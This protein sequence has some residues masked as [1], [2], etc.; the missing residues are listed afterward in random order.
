MVLDPMGQKQLLDAT[1]TK[2]GKN[3]RKRGLVKRRKSSGGRKLGA[4]PDGAAPATDAEQPASAQPGSPPPATPAAADAPAAAAPAPAPAPAYQYNDE[5][6]KRN[7][8]NMRMRSLAIPVAFAVGGVSLWAGLAFGLKIWVASIA[9]MVLA[10]V[11][12]RIIDAQIR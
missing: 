4:P 1:R 2:G 5:R 9:A 8:R 6:L 12:H 11:T 10:T 3:K 7:A